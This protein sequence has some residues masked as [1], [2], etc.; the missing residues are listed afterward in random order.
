MAQSNKSKT[1]QDTSR[2]G[3]VT[4]APVKHNPKRSRTA[5]KTKRITVDSFGIQNRTWQKLVI[6]V[7]LNPNKSQTITLLPKLEI[8][9]E[10]IVNNW[11]KKSL[12]IYGDQLSLVE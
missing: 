5:G 7:Q 9:V 1:N 12:S 3:S 8:R 11:V 6:T 2:E 4:P 10:G